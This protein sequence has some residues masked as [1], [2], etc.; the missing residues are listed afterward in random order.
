MV[1][2]PGG[3]FLRSG[4][5]VTSKV[6]KKR[7]SGRRFAGAL[8]FVFS[9]LSVYQGK[10]NT[11]ATVVLWKPTL[12]RRFFVHA[13]PPG[14]RRG[15]SGRA[16]AALGF[17]SAKH[18]ADRASIPRGGWRD[19]EFILF[20]C[21]LELKRRRCNV[22]KIQP[23]GRNGVCFT[24]T[25]FCKGRVSC[26][27]IDIFA[28]LWLD[29]QCGTF[30]PLFLCA[31]VL[32]APSQSA[33]SPQGLMSMHDQPFDDQSVSYGGSISPGSSLRRSGLWGWLETG[34]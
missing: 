25:L 19:R 17:L 16:L 22:F 10:Q 32:Q 21:V 27:H 34:R 1:L 6:C 12:V 13:G 14:R 33:L 18:G 23:S 8:A 26:S 11:R 5:F 15:G 9:F 7:G 4:Q 24:V 3:V 20:V 28:F 29:S 30:L 31:C 2:T